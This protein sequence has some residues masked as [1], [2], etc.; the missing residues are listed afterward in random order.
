MKA[1]ANCDYVEKSERL[2]QIY[3]LASWIVEEGMHMY[4][5]VHG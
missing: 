5:Y 2:Q 3:K 1:S 4:M